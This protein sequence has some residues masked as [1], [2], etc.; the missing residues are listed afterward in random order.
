MLIDKMWDKYEKRLARQPREVWSDLA[1]SVI[2]YTRQYF[3]ARG[4]SL[5]IKVSIMNTIDKLCTSVVNERRLTKQEKTKWN[6]LIEEFED[7]DRNT[8]APGVWDLLMTLDY[9]QS[10]PKELTID[11]LGDALGYCYQCIFGIEILHPM[12]TGESYTETELEVMEK[13]IPA[14]VEA[15]E[16]QSASIRT[17]LKK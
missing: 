8:D 12:K 14:C 2:E 16:F 7:D 13:K 9:F 1:A 15:V 6:S 3:K 11:D 5:P 17:V 10:D 4:R